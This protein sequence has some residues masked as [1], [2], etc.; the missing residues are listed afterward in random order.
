MVPRESDFEKVTTAS[1]MPRLLSLLNLRSKRLNCQLPF[2]YDGFLLP[3]QPAKHGALILQVIAHR[4]RPMLVA[5]ARGLH[6]AE[7]QLVV[8]VVD[9]VHPGHPGFNLADGLIGPAHVL[10]PDG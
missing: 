1:A 2:T 8:A 3:V 6:P 7:R 9:L 5:D 4:L 10:R